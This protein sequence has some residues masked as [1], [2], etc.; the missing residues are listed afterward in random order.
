M[1]LGYTVKPTATSSVHCV[2]DFRNQCFLSLSL[3]RIIAMTGAYNN[4]K[5][6]QYGNC[7][8]R[9]KESLNR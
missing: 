1:L 4:L 2:H 7:S 8:H 3:Q 6:H 5:Q 9:K